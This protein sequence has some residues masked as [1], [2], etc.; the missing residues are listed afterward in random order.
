MQSKVSAENE[1]EPNRAQTIFLKMKLRRIEA[2][3]IF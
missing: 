3:L 1:S 2:E